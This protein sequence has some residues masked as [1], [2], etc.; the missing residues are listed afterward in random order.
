MPMTPAQTAAALETRCGLC[1]AEPGQ[2]C[3]NP[4]GGQLVGRDV[5]W[6][7]VPMKEEG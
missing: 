1:K 5:H 6:Y 4:C 2:P 3:T 7:R